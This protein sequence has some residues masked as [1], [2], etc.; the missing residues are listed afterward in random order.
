MKFGVS[1]QK[2]RKKQFLLANSR[3]ISTN[4][5]VLGLDLHSSSP[6][7][8]NF[9]EAQSSL[10]KAHAVIWEG[11]SYGMPPVVPGLD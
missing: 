8:V 9:F 2:L 1:P 4:L 11:H 10:G 7:P 5:R 3:T 6:E